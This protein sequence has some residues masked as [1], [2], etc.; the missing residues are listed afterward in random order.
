VGG[1]RRGRGA[2]GGDWEGVG[3]LE[4]M[5][6]SRSRLHKQTCSGRNNP[7]PRVYMSSEFLCNILC[8]Q[9][10]ADVN[11]NTTQ[12]EAN[13]MPTKAYPSHVVVDASHCST[14]IRTGTQRRPSHGTRCGLN[15]RSASA[16]TTA[17]CLMR[18]NNRP[19]VE[20]VKYRVADRPTFAVQRLRVKA[21]E[22]SVR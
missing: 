11:I 15:C 10:E 1:R 21:T 18:Q 14:R 17:W 12:R 3:G 13:S 4:P 20:V 16:S 2:G 19:P 8:R 7:L 22:L 6:I 5:H 9:Q